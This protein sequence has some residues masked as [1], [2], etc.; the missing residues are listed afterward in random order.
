MTDR[1]E[2]QGIL[3]IN[4]WNGS[5]MLEDALPTRTPWAQ[6]EKTSTR[7]NCLA[8]AVPADQRDWM[9]PEPK[10]PE[11]T[12]RL[13]RFEICSRREGMRRSCATAATCSRDICGA[14]IRIC[15]PKIYLHRRPMRGL[16]RVGFH[17]TC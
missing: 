8:P 6:V 11:A 15:Q 13:R 4:A 7:L 5:V 16:A 3:Q 2:R 1:I 14:T 10:R 17:N 12:T 9:H